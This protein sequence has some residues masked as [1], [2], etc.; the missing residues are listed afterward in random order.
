M[1]LLTFI[2]YSVIRNRIIAVWYSE[3]ICI[4]ETVSYTSNV[5][6]VFSVFLKYIY[7]LLHAL[8]SD[9]IIHLIYILCAES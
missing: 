6:I 9:V 3:L 7:L 5:D 4:L 2:K 8:S 1:S